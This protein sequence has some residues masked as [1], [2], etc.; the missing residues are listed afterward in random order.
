MN[1]SNTRWLKVDSFRREE[2][3]VGFR[4]YWIR[5]ASKVG[6]LVVTRMEEDCL[7]VDDEADQADHL[8]S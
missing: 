6:R 5:K 1:N 7:F 4:R 2:V 8:C 3:L